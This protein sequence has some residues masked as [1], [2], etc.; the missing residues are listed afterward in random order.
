VAPVG[1]KISFVRGNNVHTYIH[2]HLGADINAGA[3]FGGS[4]LWLREPAI[5]VH[6]YVEGYLGSDI[7]RFRFFMN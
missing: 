1:R 5:D 4:P 6:T 3:Y 7:E 2:G